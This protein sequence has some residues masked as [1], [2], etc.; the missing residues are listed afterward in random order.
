M[1]GED[2]SEIGVRIFEEG[3]SGRHLRSWFEVEVG[4]SV[5]HTVPAGHKIACGLWPGHA[6]D[7]PLANSA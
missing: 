7:E 6:G 3:S 4:G 1:E 2:G 5:V